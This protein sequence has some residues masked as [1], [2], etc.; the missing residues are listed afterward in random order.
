MTSTFLL[1]LSEISGDCEKI[2][3]KCYIPKLPGKQQ[4]CEGLSNTPNTPIDNQTHRKSVRER[5][6]K[7]TKKYRVADWVKVHVD[8]RPDSIGS[9][10]DG[11]P[12]QEY[13]G[14]AAC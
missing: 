14:F 1:R 11:L 3:F 2:V 6:S 12:W 4:Q 9:E 8:N 5:L 7:Y 10:K 13:I